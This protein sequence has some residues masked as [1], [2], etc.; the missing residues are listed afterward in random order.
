[1]NV[2]KPLNPFIMVSVYVPQCR[3]NFFHYWW[4]EEFDLLKEASIETNR[5]WKAAGKPRSGLIFQKRQSARMQYRKNLK[6]KQNSDTLS[7]TN[8]LHDSLLRKNGTTFWKC[9]RSKFEH[10]SRYSQVDGCVDPVVIADKFANY[11]QSIYT[12]NNLSGK[13]IKRRIS[14][15]A[16]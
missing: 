5:I 6:E 10:K 16:C 9:W 13:S 2:T 7:Y 12:C 1:M 11:F 4:N 8:D 3:K 14:P 15:K